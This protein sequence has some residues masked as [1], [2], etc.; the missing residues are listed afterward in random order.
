MGLYE[1]YSN[2]NP[3]HTKNT[4]NKWKERNPVKKMTPLM[5][6]EGIMLNEISYTGKTDT[7]WFH[8]YME[9]KKQNK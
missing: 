7:I 2:I 5:N 8:L 9:S 6:L 3:S 1:P 4:Q